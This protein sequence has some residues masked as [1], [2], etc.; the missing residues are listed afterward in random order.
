MIQFNFKKDERLRLKIEIKKKKWGRYTSTWE[1]KG[2]SD[3]LLF[4]RMEHWVQGLFGFV[5]LNW[6]RW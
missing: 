5:E 2:R 4:T 3:D 1:S 6:N